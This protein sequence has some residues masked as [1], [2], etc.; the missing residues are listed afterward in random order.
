M[1]TKHLSSITLAC[2][3]LGILV[4]S[5]HQKGKK[6]SAAGANSSHTYN[7]IRE[8][9]I[10]NPHLA[11]NICDT[12]EANGEMKQFYLDHLR[13]AI[14][15]NGLKMK[16]LSHYYGL[17]A[18]GDKRFEKTD[19][20]SYLFCLRLMAEQD[21]KDSRYLS[22]MNLA[23]QCVDKARKY[24]YPDTENKM[25]HL[26]GRCNV[27][28]GNKDA[29]YKMMNEACVKALDIFKD[30]PDLYSA[31]EIVFGY[32]TMLEMMFEQGQPK[33]ALPCIGEME[34]RLDMVEK[35]GLVPEAILDM[36]QCAIYA[37]IMKIY[38]ATGNI[39]MGQHY[40]DKA[41]STKTAKSN[42]GDAF[43]TFHYLATRQYGKLLA[44]TKKMRKVFQNTSDTIS[45]DYANKVLIKELEAYDAMG[46]DRKAK[47]IAMEIITLKDSLEKRSQDNDLLQLSKMYETQEKER[48]LVEQDRKLARQ[49]F[50]LWAAVVLLA[51][52]FAFIA[53]MIYYNRKINKRS[54]AA[55]GTISRLV[56]Q[57]N[58]LSK[59][60]P[61]GIADG[62]TDKFVGEMCFRKAISMLEDKDEMEVEEIACACGYKDG[63]TFVKQFE[64][65]YGLTPQE[66]R[67][68]SKM[69]KKENNDAS[70][71]KTSFIRNMSHEIRTPLNQISGF[72]QLLTDPNINLE[73]SQK[74]EL[75]NIIIEQTD[76][77]M[78]MLNDLIEISE[79]E[80]SE[81]KLDVAEVSV[82]DI[83]AAVSE[84]RLEASA[85]VTLEY[86]MTG[87]SESVTTNLEAVVRIMGCLVDNAIKNTTSGSIKVEY[88]NSGGK[89]V[90]SVTDT[91]RG[92][93]AD[94][95]EK[96]FERF[97]KIDEFVPG[98]GLG[99]TLSR[100][101]A[102][103]ID[104]TVSLDTSYSGGARFLV[105]LYGK[106]D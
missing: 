89:A 28:V 10:S 54:K 48:L 31:D 78:K 56:E 98:V 39:K 59:L 23:R 37:L 84:T 76:H 105:A 83:F 11:L 25:Q 91:G 8:I 50:G 55:V 21:Y 100:A 22:A 101:I 45:N 2:L 94:K 77:M 34:R 61:D 62:D 65:Q 82:N 49:S 73:G 102:A 9:H 46:N 51:I 92:I 14:Y 38:D 64:S 16:R 63:K 32:G 72:V 57:Q 90:L 99:L 66:Y 93:P 53:L 41:A 71:M 85:G 97:Y 4:S 79:Y 17:R 43:F 69:T 30:N 1:K 35:S 68:W 24:G 5:C 6:T 86:C 44:V 13:S 36:R 104:A 47:Q 52:A 95:A 60:R 20:E 74:Q 42:T 33:D 75:N 106:K 3:L 7:Y 19:P 12:M 103:K 58:E 80:G 27:M 26:I 70:E 87:A 96:I 15:H 18:V 67:R 88:A 29:G 81:D 40:C